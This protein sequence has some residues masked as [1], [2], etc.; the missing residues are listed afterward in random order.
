MKTLSSPFSGAAYNTKLLCR[1]YVSE[2]V[3]DRSQMY[4]F[5]GTLG[6]WASTQTGEEPEVTRNAAMATAAT[7][8]VPVQARVPARIWEGM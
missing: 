8:P 3:A 5:R 6:G 4:V 1:M 7:Q 2:S